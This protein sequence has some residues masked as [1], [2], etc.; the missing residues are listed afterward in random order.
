MLSFSIPLSVRAY[1]K[2]HRHVKP[3][4]CCRSIHVWLQRRVQSCSRKLR[5]C[6][7]KVYPLNLPLMGSY[8]GRKSIDSCLPNQRC[9]H[10]FLAEHKIDSKSP[11][12]VSS[13]SITWPD[14]IV[15]N[16][17]SDTSFHLKTV[18]SYWSTQYIRNYF[19]V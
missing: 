14:S 3:N 19:C 16:G 18:F 10:C 1:K 12:I 2:T 17:Y 8:M 7:H 11:F 9:V 13:H 15:T 5:E 6:K 4:H